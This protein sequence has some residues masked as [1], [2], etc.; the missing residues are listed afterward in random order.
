M[1]NGRTMEALSLN[2]TSSPS[3]S[4]IFFTGIVSGEMKKI[5]KY[6]IKLVINANVEIQNSSC[7]C[8]AGI[9]AHPT[10]KDIV[11]V[12]FLLE[13]FTNYGDLTLQKKLYGDFQYTIETSLSITC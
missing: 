10:C 13:D 3:N 12:L 11:A 1:K 2:K 8:S 4:T 6:Y 7:E 9:G 5:K